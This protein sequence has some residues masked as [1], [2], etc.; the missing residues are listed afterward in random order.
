MIWRPNILAKM[1]L[2]A[3]A[4]RG[5]SMFRFRPHFQRHEGF[6]VVDVDAKDVDF[7][8]SIAL[9]PS[10]SDVANFEQ[11]FLGCEYD[12]RRIPRYAEIEALYRSMRRP[13]I[14][15]L[16][17]YIGLA[18]VFFRKCWP[19]AKIV[20]VEPDRENILMI[21]RNAPGVQTLHAAVASEH[22][23]ANIVNSEDAGWALRTQVARDGAI[24]AVTVPEIIANNADCEPFICKIDIEGAE[25]ELFSKNTE[26]LSRFPV[27]IIELHDW[28]FAGEATSRNF[29]RTVAHHD[30]DFVLFGENVWSIANRLNRR[31]DDAR[32]VA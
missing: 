23:R 7:N 9:R 25:S 11:I 1:F 20:A 8:A 14:V 17:A 24:E 19:R 28:R 21:R 27:V 2:D 31:R 4:H 15:D 6:N 12:F 29:I 5:A 32:T 13:L 18:A 16:G 3:R 10:G 26:W 30:R 22:G